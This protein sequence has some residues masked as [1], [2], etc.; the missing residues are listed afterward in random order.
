MSD[1]NRKGFH[2]KMSYVSPRHRMIAKSGML[3]ENA[4]R[5]AQAAEEELQ[6]IFALVFV[7]L[8]IA[9]IIFLVLKALGII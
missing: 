1:N 5:D 9:G 4:K 2:Y 8:L 3:G 6:P 7:C